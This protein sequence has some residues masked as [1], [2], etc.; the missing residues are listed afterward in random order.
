MSLAKK[1]ENLER[2]ALSNFSIL[3]YSI[4]ILY[5]GEYSTDLGTP[6]ETFIAYTLFL[7]NPQFLPDDYETRS[8]LST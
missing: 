8:K 6:I 4:Y 2:S 3:E 5:E 7:K 1:M